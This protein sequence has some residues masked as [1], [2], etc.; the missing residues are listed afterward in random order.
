MFVRHKVYSVKVIALY[1]DSSLKSLFMV[2]AT[3]VWGV[4]WFS[5]QLSR[6]LLFRLGHISGIKVTNNLGTAIQSLLNMDFENGK[7]LE[8]WPHCFLS[9]FSIVVMSFASYS[10]DGFSDRVDCHFAQRSYGWFCSNFRNYCLSLT[11]SLDHVN[12]YLWKSMDNYK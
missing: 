2:F 4:N 3:Q 1:V 7:Y 12:H 8:A 9:L 5:Q 10:N 6:C 11:E